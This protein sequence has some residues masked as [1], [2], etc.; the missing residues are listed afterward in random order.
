MNGS[1][2]FGLKKKTVAQKRILWKI[3][4]Y[5]QKTLIFELIDLANVHL[6]VLW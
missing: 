4:T 2:G 1:A 6:N 5:L 3:R